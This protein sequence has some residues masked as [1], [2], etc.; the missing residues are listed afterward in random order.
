LRSLIDSLFGTSDS[1]TAIEA[2]W[3]GKSIKISYEKYRN[4]PELLIGLL[5]AKVGQ[6]TTI[7][8]DISTV[9]S[10][11]P[12]LDIVRRAGPPSTH[13]DVIYRLVMTHLG[14]R[15][16]NVREMAA[17]ALSVL[18]PQDKWATASQ[19]LL[20]MPHESSN[21]RHGSLMA[22]RFIIERQTAINPALAIGVYYPITRDLVATCT[23]NLRAIAN[24]SCLQKV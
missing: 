7:Q 9:E 6:S 3:D 5:S 15:V 13:R 17:H 14:S 23:T 11:F 10:V 22:V 4:L 24:L 21:L 2:G 16:W 1:K 8:P 19:E 20:D 12:A 18:V